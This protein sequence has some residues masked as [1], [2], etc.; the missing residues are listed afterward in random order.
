MP[1]SERKELAIALGLTTDL[2]E[3]QVGQLFQIL[4]WEAI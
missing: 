3:S 1:D 2:E 4:R